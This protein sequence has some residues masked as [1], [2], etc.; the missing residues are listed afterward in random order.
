MACLIGIFLFV[1]VGVQPV[2]ADTGL[3]ISLQPSYAV[4]ILGTRVT[5][6]GSSISISGSVRRSD[7]WAPTGW[8][9][10][11]ISLFGDL[12]ALIKRVEADYSPRPIPHN[13]HSAYESRARFLITIKGVTRPVRRVEIAY[14]NGSISHPQ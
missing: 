4:E 11:E 10:L 14:W 8:G 3:I 7:P 1:C 2:R 9:H 13:F 6:N 5:Q 12:G